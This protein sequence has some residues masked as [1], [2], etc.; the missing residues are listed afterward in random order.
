[1]SIDFYLFQQINQFAGHWPYLDA[2][3]VFFAK[4]LGYILIFSLFLFLVKNWK[5]YWPMA[6]WALAGAV[7]ARYVIVNIIRWLWERPRPFVENQI[8]L[9]L[10]HEATGSFP[11][12]H[13]AFYFAIATVIYLYNKKI[14]ILFFIGSFLIGIARVFVG[15]HWPSDILGG[16]LVGIFF[17]FLVKK[18]FEKFLIS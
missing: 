9:L 12:G 15:L 14:G 8:N 6:I 16:V 13:A 5:K 3:A 18:F 17:V 7:L 4:Y 1:M 10:P 11:S 2:I